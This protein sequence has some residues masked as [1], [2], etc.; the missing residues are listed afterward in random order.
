M[1]KVSSLGSVG[2]LLGLV[3]SRFTVIKYGVN[4][5]SIILFTILTV[6]MLCEI[7]LIIRREYIIAV[8]SLSMIIPLVLITIGVYLDNVIVDFIGIGLI[9]ILIPLMIK[10]L[11]RYKN[12][13]SIK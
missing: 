10:F 12:N 13:S 7:L 3:I 5:R 4:A 2:V 8:C 1:K 6:C 9:F 11:K